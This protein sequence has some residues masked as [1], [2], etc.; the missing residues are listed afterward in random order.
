[1]KIS[2]LLPYKENF[3]PNYAGAVSINIKDTIKHS[4]YKNMI[5]VYGS[6]THKKKYHK[7]Y[8]NLIFKNNF[9]TSSSK[10]YLRKFV[11]EENK[12][13]SDFIEI[14][15][16]PEYIEFLYKYNSNLVLFYH[17][18]PLS[19]RYSKTINERSKLIQKTKKIIFNS[20]WTKKRFL[21]GLKLNS[22]TRKKFEV[23]HQSID[24]VNI[25]LKKKKKYYYIYW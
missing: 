24:R 9:L 18:D 22:N 10:A 12:K 21:I 6:T 2:I 23:I 3:S 19:M 5:T 11:E 16:R 13:K 17:N 25:N 8:K 20:N 4:K 15:N 1:M 7:S 14:H